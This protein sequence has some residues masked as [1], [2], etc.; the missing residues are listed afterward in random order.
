MPKFVYFGHPLIV[1]VPRLRAAR[2]GRGARWETCGAPGS[3]TGRRPASLP[4]RCR[5]ACSHSGEVERTTVVFASTVRSPTSMVVSPD[6]ASMLAGP[7]GVFV[8]ATQGPAD[9]IAVAVARPTGGV[10]PSWPM[11]RPTWCSN[12][13]RLPSKGPPTTPPL[14]R[15]V[16]MDAL[17]SVER[18][19]PVVGPLPRGAAHRGPCGPSRR[20]RSSPRSGPVRRGCAHAPRPCSVTP[21]RCGVAVAVRATGNG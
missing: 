16:V 17:Q 9:Q 20:C 1:L 3:C 11:R 2:R 12:T 10:A 19:V 21:V 4:S 15:R 6:P 8:R 14:V 13:S 5:R 18:R 7:I